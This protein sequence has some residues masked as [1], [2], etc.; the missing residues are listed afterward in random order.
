MLDR[1]RKTIS[2]YNMLPEG[3]RVIVAVSGGADSVCLLHVLK[4]LFP[5]RL[6][7]VGHFNHKWRAE[8]S[9]EDERFV[10]QLARQF[11]LPFHRA[12]ATPMPGNKEQNARRARQAF[13]AT[14]GETVALGHT[15]DDQAETVLFRFLRGSGLAGLAGIAPNAHGLI[16]PLLEITRAEIEQFLSARNIPWREDAT[17]QDLT[18]ARN[19]IRYDLLPQ[20]ACDWNPK[21]TEALA[22]LA[23][24]AH[25]EEQYWHSQI[26]EIKLIHTGNAIELPANL[27]SAGGASFSL[28]RRLQPASETALHP[29]AA[30][31]LI[32]RAIQLAKGDLRQIDF[33]HIEAVRNL[34]R[35]VHLPGLTVTRSFDWIRFAPSAAPAPPVPLQ[36]TP[37]GKFPSPDGQT[38]ICVDLAQSE[39]CDTLSMEACQISS[40][41]ELRGWRPGDHYR[42]QGHS[43][44][45]KIQEMFQKARV[46]SWRRASWPILT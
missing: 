12:E 27:T 13:F 4:E 21:I 15:R 25:E 43:R 34:R 40:P 44:D 29:A 18:F 5:D 41:L 17:N 33:D 36:I 35:R 11:A 3:V 9:D 20:L 28:Q 30:R 42:P 2:R 1:V 19:R 45:Q 23:D 46:P 38:Q 16:R 37:P 22:H 26:D 24:L 7:G 10:A 31:R 32:R 14:L 8:A 39:A 6:A